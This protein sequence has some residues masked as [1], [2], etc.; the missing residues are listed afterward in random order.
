[1]RASHVTGL[2]I[3]IMSYREGFIQGRIRGDRVLLYLG[4]IDILQSYKLKKKLEHTMKSIITDG[5]SYLV[6]VM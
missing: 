5:V 2:L 1:M 4:V 6:T 3:I